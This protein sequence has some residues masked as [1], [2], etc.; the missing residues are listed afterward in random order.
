MEVSGVANIAGADM[1]S[2]TCSYVHNIEK[3]TG[4]KL[5]VDNLGKLR[6]TLL[7]MKIEVPSQDSWRI[8]CLRKFLSEK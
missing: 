6:Q 7:N 5:T 8:G 3:E 2:I 4:L 1:R